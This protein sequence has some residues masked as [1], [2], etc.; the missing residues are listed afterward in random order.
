MN[1]DILEA[2]LIG[3]SA[4]EGFFNNASM[5]NEYENLSDRE[6]ATMLVDRMVQNQFVRLA[7]KEDDM[8]NKICNT[9]R[10]TSKYYFEYNIS[11]Y[12][13]G[14]SKKNNSDKEVSFTYFVY[15]PRQNKYFKP[16]TVT[17]SELINEFIRL[18]SRR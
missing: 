8:V 15:I 7:T 10:Y 4:L 18:D 2:L 1:S 6:L 3:K 12:P 16:I 17:K 5:P 14:V 9:L 11:G 13:V